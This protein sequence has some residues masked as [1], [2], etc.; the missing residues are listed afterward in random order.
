MKK[1]PVFSLFIREFGCGEQFAADCVIRHNVI[2][3]LRVIAVIVGRMRRVAAWERLNPLL[4]HSRI[5]V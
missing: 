3:Y 5:E 4:P 2:V 1:F